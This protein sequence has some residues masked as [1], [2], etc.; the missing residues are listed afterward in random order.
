MHLVGPSLGS[1][2][3]PQRQKEYSIPGLSCPLAQH[4]VGSVRFVPPMA[5]EDAPTLEDL[6]LAGRTGIL[7]AWS[8][9]NAWALRV[10]DAPKT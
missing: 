3:L 4:S 2:T 8:E 6:W 10:A 5:S 7:A 9:A 1:R